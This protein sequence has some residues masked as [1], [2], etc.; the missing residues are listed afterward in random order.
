M[1]HGYVSLPKG[2]ICKEC[3]LAKNKGLIIHPQ[4]AFHAWDVIEANGDTM[5][6]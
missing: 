2:N 1:F 6:H 5:K 3:C 4:P